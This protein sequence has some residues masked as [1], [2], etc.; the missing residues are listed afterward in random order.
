MLRSCGE[1]QEGGG[2]GEVGKQRR[3]ELYWLLRRRS[4]RPPTVRAAV[5]AGFAVEP[6]PRRGLVAVYLM[7]RNRRMPMSLGAGRT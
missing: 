7:T 5:R 3:S 2:S 1:R 6:E 4:L